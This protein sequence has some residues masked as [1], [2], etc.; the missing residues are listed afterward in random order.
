MKYTDKF[1]NCMT[2]APPPPANFRGF[3]CVTR[4]ILA[5]SKKKAIAHCINDLTYREM[6]ADL[7]LNRAYVRARCRTRRRQR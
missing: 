3:L 4:L 1:D 6:T 5:Y 2:L 7:R